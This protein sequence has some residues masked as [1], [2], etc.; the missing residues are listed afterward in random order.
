MYSYLSVY[1]HSVYK[2]SP[3]SLYSLASKATI[4]PAKDI[5]VPAEK[6]QAE[7]GESWEKALKEGRACNALDACKIFQCNAKELDAA[8][9]KSKKVVKFGGGFYC[10]LVSMKD[11][12]LYVFNAFF[13]TM[14]SKFV[15][16]GTSIHCYEVQWSPSKLS[17]D[18][19][20]NKVLGPTDPVDGPAG[21][22]RKT[23]LEQWKKLGLTS[24]PNKGDN[25]V[26]A[27]AS[28]FEGL[29]EKSNW[30]G[31][32]AS[33]D[34]FGAA[35]LKAGL[36]A[37]TIKEWSVD[38]RVT[39]ADGSKGSVFDALEDLDAGDCLAKMVELNG[40][41]DGDMI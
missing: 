16:P 41:S 25:G 36:S 8:W 24:E 26:H 6:F 27:S 29:A 37:A 28:P 32:N 5:P 22:I 15:E 34:P 4:L 11:K 19:F 14:R 30:L 1:S 17:W 38:P 2:T 40:F 35:L 21:S 9:G 13:M 3:F 33:E 12:E 20:R 39:Q 7:F 18:A 31:N 10:G 23:I